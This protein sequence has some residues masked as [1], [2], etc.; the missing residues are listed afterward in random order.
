MS[1]ETQSPDK[2][3][4]EHEQAQQQAAERISPRAARHGWTPQEARAF[5]EWDGV[6]A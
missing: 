1:D 5:R 4:A 2:R 6:E 3:Q